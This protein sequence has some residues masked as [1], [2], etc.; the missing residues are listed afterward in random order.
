M[1]THPTFRAGA[2][3]ASSEFL[4]RDASIAKVCRYIEEASEQ[5]VDLLA[6]PETFV[7]GYPFWIWTHTPATGAPLFFE[8]HGNS[9]DL[10]TDQL[11]PVQDAARKASMLVVLGVSE[12]E[13]AT[14]YNTQVFIGRDGE[15]LGRRR[16]LQPTHV[17]RTI[18]G[19]GDGADLPVFDTDV[20]RIGGLICWEHTMDLARY[21]LTSR[22]QQVHI[23]AWPGISA[24]TH[25]PNSGFF[26]KV[27]EAAVRY[28]AWAA[29]TFV[30]NTSSV[31]D[32]EVLR[33]LGLEDQPD[34]IRTG[35]GWSAIVSPS[36]QMLAGPATEEETLLV[37]DID[38]SEIVFLKY[39]CDSAGHYARP[40][41]LRLATDLRPQPLTQDL[42]HQRT[43]VDSFDQTGDLA[44]ERTEA[45]STER[46]SLDNGG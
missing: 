10:A 44:G 40:D 13:G 12:K 18:W 32:Q 45:E 26:N 41:M 28:H 19:R 5:G 9:V 37:A 23:G 31:I 35:G 43:G 11:R 24:L 38:L 42:D 20:G 16:K 33:R 8:L 29:Q 25:D 6:F 27:V 17:E 39:A 21:S 30:I 22:G 14:L 4:N 36:G 34:M 46:Q 2:V 7:P 1:D 3:Q 15:I